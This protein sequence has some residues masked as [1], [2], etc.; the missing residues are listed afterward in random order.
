MKQFIKK[1]KYFLIII[2][3]F[4]NILN[5]QAVNHELPKNAFNFMG[6]IFPD[7]KIDNISLENDIYEVR[8]LNEATIS[9]DG[10]GDW[11]KIDSSFDPIPQTVFPE[12][13]LNS[14]SRKFKNPKIVHA[15]KYDK[16]YEKL[17]YEVIIYDKY[18]IFAIYI[19]EDGEILDMHFLKSM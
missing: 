5:A 13:V 9:F 2:V 12:K 6:F 15:N 19:K 4:S 16:I 10:Y 17:L 3:L 18:D 11:I 14:I 8:L 7:F 1:R